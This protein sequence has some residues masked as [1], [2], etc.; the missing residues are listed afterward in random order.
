MNINECVSAILGE[1][2]AFRRKL[3]QNPELSQK[4]YETTNLIESE[5]TKLGIRV[6]RN[7]LDTGIIGIIDGKYPGK[8]L[9]LRADID[10][11]PMN[12]ETNLEFKSQNVGV[13][14]TCGHDIHSSVLLGSA[15]VLAKNTDNLSGTIK[16]IFQPAEETMY[17]ANAV[18]A[19][20]ALDDADAIIGC[21]CWPDIPAGTVGTR[22]GS[23]MAASDKVKLTVK[24]K[25]GHAAHPHKCVDPIVV[26]AYLITQIQTIISRTL[27]PLDSNV[28][29]FGQ[30][31]GGT[32]SNIIPN[33]VVL[34]GTI[35]SVNP[36]SRK[37]I[38][39]QIKKMAENSAIAMNAE[40]DVHI[41]KGTPPVISDNSILDII[42]DATRKTIG[43][44]NLVNLAEPSMGSED[45]AF[46]LEKVPGAFFR[47]GTANNDPAT[48]L[49]LHNS[50]IIFDESAIEAGIKVMSSTALSYLKGK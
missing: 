49:P 33:E 26:S 43:E 38:H 41:E 21:H 6:S 31:Q 16:L 30:I 10:A 42:E 11:L 28:I 18:I 24:G 7:G 17:G 19:S 4:E 22:R 1:A 14:H 46:Y 32:A 36:E 13:A 50:G 20:G 34:K 40:C 44:E 37:K 48:H 35:R 3:H 47:I 25:G 45:F 12:E 29:T 2:A 23:I 27:G 9:A 5:L 39:E 8:T 15:M